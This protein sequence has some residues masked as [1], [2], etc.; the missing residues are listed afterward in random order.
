MD[1]APDGGGGHERGGVGATFCSSLQVRMRSVNVI[2]KARGSQ[3][4]DMKDGAKCHSHLLNPA[5]N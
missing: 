5:A 4:R 1:H 2:Q 3:W